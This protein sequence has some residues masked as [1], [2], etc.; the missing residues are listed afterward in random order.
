MG[1]DRSV[2]NRLR[3]DWKRRVW[4]EVLSERERGILTSD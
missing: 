4:K 2:G 3:V 1:I